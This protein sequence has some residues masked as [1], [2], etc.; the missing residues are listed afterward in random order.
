[1]AEKDDKKT[2]VTPTPPGS[3]GG[4][5]G[6]G[7]GGKR[8]PS[9]T[10]TPDQ[11]KAIN[12]ML[13]ERMKS[14]RG[15]ASSPNNPIS[16]YNL[17]DPKNIET[18]KVSRF[19]AKWVVGFKDLQN[20]PYKKTPKYLRYGV[21][22]IR[23]L[24]NEPYVTLILSTDGE[25]TEEKEVLLLDYMENRERVDVKVI[26]IRVEEKINDHGILGQQNNYGVAIDDKGQPEARPTIL[27]QS[28]SVIRWFTVQPEGF[29]EPMEFSTD[30]LA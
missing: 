12:L 30:F 29:S 5:D 8:A 18:V 20:D 15:S 17:R 26:K 19:D 27:A 3:T 28:K 13:E 1:M 9:V 4:D 25:K 10:F 6:E 11:I 7:K 24:N 14:V 22:P 23:K 21:D 2:G 16:L